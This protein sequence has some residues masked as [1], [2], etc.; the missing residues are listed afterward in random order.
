MGRGRIRSLLTLVCAAALAAAPASATAQDVPAAD[1]PH[2]LGCDFTDP[3]VCLYPWPNNVYT[4]ADP[5]TPTGRRVDLQ[6]WA[7]PRNVAGKPIDPTDY[8]R[9]DGFSPG[10]MIVTKVP[11]LDTQAA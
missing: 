10:Q 3:S 2:A 11:G 8:N 7:M 5:S 4:K 6:Q 9:A 1:L